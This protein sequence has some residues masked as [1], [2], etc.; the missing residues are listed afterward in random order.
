MLEKQQL[1]FG[2]ANLRVSDAS[3]KFSEFY[4]LTPV[5]ELMTFRPPGSIALQ[6]HEKISVNLSVEK[7]LFYSKIWTQAGALTSLHDALLF[8]RT[9]LGQGFSRKPLKPLAC[10]WHSSTSRNKYVAQ[11][12]DCLFPAS[13]FVN[14]HLNL[15]TL[16]CNTLHI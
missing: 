1:C 11:I 9:L 3:L 13:G 16:R 14:L 5:A 15:C 2:A 7:I 6:T 4:N 10:L 8:Y 12:C